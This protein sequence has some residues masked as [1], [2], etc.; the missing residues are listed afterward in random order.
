MPDRK[1][2]KPRSTGSSRSEGRS[3]RKS[4]Q[5][6]GPSQ[7]DEKLDR[8]PEGSNGDVDRS[9]DRAGRQEGV[10][11]SSPQGEVEETGAREVVDERQRIRQTTHYG[12][13]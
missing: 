11:S 7:P 2:R 4:D 8:A 3:R 1:S 6:V 12:K 5:P 10:E 9:P 13:N